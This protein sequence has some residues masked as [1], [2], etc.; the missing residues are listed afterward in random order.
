MEKHK[1]NKRYK[2]TGVILVA[3]LLT[4]IL[5]QA[6]MLFFTNQLLPFAQATR[7]GS[8]NHEVFL[9][10]ASLRQATQLV[11]SVCLAV[12]TWAGLFWLHLFDK[13]HPHVPFS[14]LFCALGITIAA[15]LVCTIPFSLLDTACQYDYF[16]P[17][18]NIFIRVGLLFALWFLSNFV[19][20]R[21]AKQTQSLLPSTPNT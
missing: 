16:F 3:V 1:I 14:R 15:V 11:C 6:C 9:A 8:Q 7:T 20:Y 13:N 5:V 12:F 18:W 4:G 21:R 10:R 17:L 2:I 19:K